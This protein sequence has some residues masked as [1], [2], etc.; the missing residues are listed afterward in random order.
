MTTTP[1]IDFDREETV[2][3]YGDSITEQNLYAA[4]LETFLTTRWP[5]KKLLFYNFGWGGD[6]AAGGAARYRRDV[7]PVKPTRVLVNFGMNDGAYVP[8]DEK[9]R[10][11]Y[12]G[13]QRLLADAIAAGGAKQILF[14]T[15]AVDPDRNPSLVPYNDA[16]DRFAAGVTDLGAERKLPV[17]DLFHL[18]REFQ[19][20]AKKKDPAFSMVPDGV[21]PNE[22]G[23]FVM[24]YAACKRFD[25]PTGLGELVLGAK[26]VTASGPATVA[27]VRAEKGVLSFDLKLPFL[28]FFV[29]D[30][31]RPALALVPFQE[32]FNRFRLKVADWPTDRT[33]SLAIDGC[34]VCV[35]APDRREAGIDLS[36]LDRTPWAVQGR[37]LWDQAQQR[38][39]RHFEAWRQMGFDTPATFRALPS[40][41]RL[42]AAQRDF[43]REQ[44]ALLR[45]FV[46]PRTV[47]VS[48]AE[49]SAIDLGKIEL[50]PKY[51]FDPA[52]QA[53]FDTAHPPETAPNRVAWTPVELRGFA[54]DL[55]AHFGGGPTNCVA[56]ARLVLEADRVCQ[57]RLIL[58]SDDGISVFAEGR[59]VFAHNIFRGLN[60]GDDQTDV[61]LKPGRN[62]I[63]LRVTQGGG[64]WGLAVKAQIL[65]EA[66]VRQV[67]P[68]SIQTAEET[69]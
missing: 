9:I 20:Q 30:L 58:G 48:L 51:P 17:I 43:V 53:D 15:S 36:T 54:V 23:H 29:P 2:V 59:R 1:P 33:L 14:T 35:I 25:V 21:H 60:L 62:T 8:Y 7:A 6:N 49:T 42:V 3:F 37:L 27:N 13:N 40:F 46:Q 57:V 41:D 26:G 28:P 32:E 65:G 63:L 44:G 61:D 4:Y 55:C 5:D 69:A 39:R 47:R 38:W 64:A 12:L 16:L 10:A 34:E 31:A 45:D 18:C 56:Y 50:S 11:A 66:K 19:A 22:V 67:A 68:L 52:S 24:F